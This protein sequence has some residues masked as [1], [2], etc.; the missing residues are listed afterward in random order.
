MSA[1]Y[2]FIL[3]AEGHSQCVEGRDEMTTW[4]HFRLY[5]ASDITFQQKLVWLALLEQ[6]VFSYFNMRVQNAAK[7]FKSSPKTEK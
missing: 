1:P 6:S 7:I 4:P 2:L 3:G 5:L